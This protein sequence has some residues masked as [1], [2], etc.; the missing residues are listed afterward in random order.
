MTNEKNAF[1]AARQ[2][3][4]SSSDNL[5]ARNRLWWERMPMTY[6]DWQAKD[7]LP[8]KAEDLIGLADRVLEEGP[9]LRRWFAERRFDGLRVLDLGCGS[10]VFTAVLAKAGGTVTGVD[11]TETGVRLARTSGKVN[12]LPLT[13]ARMDAEDLA[14]RDGVFD[15]VFSWG[16]LHHTANME[17]AVGEASRVLKPGGRGIIMVYHRTSVVYWIHGLFWL[18]V[19]GKI[20]RGFTLRSIQDLYTDGFYHRYLTERELGTM[21]SAKGLHPERFVV[22]Q[23]RKRILPFIP[24]IL[25]DA[26]KGRFG[27]CLVAEF[28]R[29]P[30][31][32]AHQTSDSSAPARVERRRPW[33]RVVTAGLWIWTIAML[34]AYLYQFRDLLR[35]TL[36]LLG[37]T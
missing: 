29:A 19:K 16:V 31:T 33:A 2:A 15:F 10:G 17:R 8:A 3:A 24:H 23:Y 30:A 28:T 22:T 32:F 6:S 4:A 9:W 21:L 25:D 35:P 20:L 36:A 18:L 11:I 7:R 14:F 26:L 13:V 1:I 5:Q 27:M 12:R 34:T 37:I